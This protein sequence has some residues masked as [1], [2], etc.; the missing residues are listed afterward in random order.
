MA[1]WHWGAFCEGAVDLGWV[2]HNGSDIDKSLSKLL[3]HHSLAPGDPE[4]LLL[5]PNCIL[6]PH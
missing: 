6:T 2:P 5:P 3:P 1:D 4:E